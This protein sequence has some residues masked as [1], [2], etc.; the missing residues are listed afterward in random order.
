VSVGRLAYIKKFLNENFFI[1]NEEGEILERARPVVTAIT[2]VYKPS[3]RE[4][5]SLGVGKE[6]SGKESVILIKL[7]IEYG[8]EIRNGREVFG[9]LSRISD[10][11]LIS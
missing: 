6:F 3:E 9:V 5:I 4:E 8:V 2:G 1:E 7:T 10:G 11:Q